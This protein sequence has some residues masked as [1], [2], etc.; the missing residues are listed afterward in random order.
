VIRAALLL[1]PLV[2]TGCS[3]GFHN[4]PTLHWAGQV[5]PTADP[6]HCPASRGTLNLREGVAVFA[7]DDG[8]WLLTGKADA[9][10]LTASASRLNA[11][12]TLYK[13][14]LQAHW[15]EQAVTGTYT[16]PFCSY[17]VELAHY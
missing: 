5:I 8:T 16:T 6:A 10:T 9:D 11:D 15:T 4:R 13:T 1:A 17:R 2:L 3:L 7:P 12:H 14:D